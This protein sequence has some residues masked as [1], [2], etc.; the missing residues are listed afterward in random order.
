MMLRS[1]RKKFIAANLRSWRVIIM[2][3]CGEYLGSVEA[4]DRERA[5]AVAIKAVCLGPGPASA[6]PDP[7]AALRPVP[8]RKIPNMDDHDDFARVRRENKRGAND[9]WYWKNK[10][11]MEVGSHER[12]SRGRQFQQL[13]SRGREDSPDCE[14]V[15]AVFVTFIVELGNALNWFHE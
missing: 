4:P 9:F 7:G 1:K 13:R 8:K 11:V 6:A 2:R 5:E 14:R 10:P 12:C 15:L 3:S